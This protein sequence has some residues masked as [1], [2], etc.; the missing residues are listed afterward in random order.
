MFRYYISSSRSDGTHKRSNLMLCS[1]TASM[2]ERKS[3][4]H[5]KDFSKDKAF[6]G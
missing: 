2:I 1:P 5:T 4:D 3:P 6:N